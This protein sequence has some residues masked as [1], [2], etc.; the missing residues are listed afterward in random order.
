M[1][2]SAKKSVRFS[3]VCTLCIPSTLC[4]AS[5]QPQQSS[6]VINPLQSSMRSIRAPAPTFPSDSSSAS[7]SC[8]MYCV[9]YG[10][11]VKYVSHIAAAVGRMRSTYVM[12]FFVFR[13]IYFSCNN[14]FAQKTPISNRQQTAAE[15][16]RSHSPGNYNS[17][18]EP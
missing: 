18:M 6:P 12:Y 7:V 14:K 3:H 1:A 9:L 11:F 15:Q 13:L 17:L 8:L 4:M 2:W 16:Y 10:S 5:I